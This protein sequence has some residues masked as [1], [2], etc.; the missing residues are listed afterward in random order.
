M[1][2]ASRSGDAVSSA[3]RATGRGGRPPT[4]TAGASP[5]R[6]GRRS[7]N[8]GPFAFAGPA[9]WAQRVGWHHQNRDEQD[10]GA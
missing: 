5:G 6:G 9:S 2:P 7:P 4:R 10:P 1:R 3:G 8:H